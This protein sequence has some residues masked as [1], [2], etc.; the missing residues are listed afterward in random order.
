MSHIAVQ[1]MAVAFL[2]VASCLTL[3]VADTPLATP[4]ESPVMIER[5][6]VFTDADPT[7]ADAVRAVVVRHGGLV[8]DE[9]RVAPDLMMLIVTVSPAAIPDLTGLPGVREVAPDVPP[10]PAGRLT[11]SGGRL[12]PTRV[13]MYS[14]P[15]RLRSAETRP[16]AGDTI[17]GGL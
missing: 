8:V 15:G 4:T 5:F 17:G 16:M 13:L 7:T 3:P 6:L 2:V 12:V 1:L 10:A 14:T 11:R 9:V